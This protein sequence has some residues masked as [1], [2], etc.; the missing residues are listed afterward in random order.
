MLNTVIFGLGMLMSLIA[1]FL[2]VN[3]I[4][5][6]TD[7]LV[8]LARMTYGVSMVLSYAIST[9]VHGTHQMQR[10]IQKLLLCIE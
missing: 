1:L 5:T 9:A 8:K 10:W 6:D 4:E 2:L 3:S 7:L